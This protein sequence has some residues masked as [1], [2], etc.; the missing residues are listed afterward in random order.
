M[1][2]SH[3]SSR[4]F[5]S[6]VL[7][8]VLSLPVVLSAQTSS[9]EEE[10]LQKLLTDSTQWYVPKTTVSIGFRLLTS[11]GNVRY[12]NLGR[13]DTGLDAVPP[14]SAG[15][16]T[17]VYNNGTVGADAVRASEKDA[18]GNQIAPDVNGRY[19]TFATVTAADGT[20]ST[21]Q[22]GDY[23]SY[24][25]GLARGWTY[26][27][28]SQVTADGRIGFSTYHAT[29]NGGSAMKDTAG[30]GGVDF[31]S[32]EPRK[33]LQSHGVG[34]DGGYRPQRHQQQDQRQRAF[35]PAHEHRFLFAE[36]QAGSYGSLRQHNSPG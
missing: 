8:T 33:V 13:V 18:N 6:A 32:L 5:K 12:G 19:Q 34:A 23:L 29:S 26:A 3:M 21:V 14:A 16:V 22:T 11:G 2:I 35:H 4:S 10:R 24:V 7:F 20:T 15:I 30:S 27:S 1:S 31:R 25:A 36:W 17:R 9:S 28:A